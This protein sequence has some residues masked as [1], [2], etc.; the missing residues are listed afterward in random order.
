MLNPG[1]FIKI[2]CGGGTQ[3]KCKPHQTTNILSIVDVIYVQNLLVQSSYFI[4]IRSVD[5]NY[6]SFWPQ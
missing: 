5:Q 3:L 1:Y 6:F 2:V 4:L